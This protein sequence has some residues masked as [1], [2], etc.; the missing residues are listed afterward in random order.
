MGK[1]QKFI[2]RDISWLSFNERVLQEAAD[3]N[4][5]LI[6]R[7]KFL[8]IFSNNLDEFFRVRFATIKRMVQFE[9]DVTLTGGLKPKQVLRMIQDVVLKQRFK[10]EEV[11]QDIL[12]KLAEQN[13]FIVN[14][15]ELTEKQGQF[16]KE[17]FL[18]KVRPVLIPIMIDRIEEFPMLRDR[19]IPCRETAEIGQAR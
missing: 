13:I 1:K 9:P 16:V 12:K 17:Y 7:L 2:N 14:E 18:E 6:E 8:G 10:F 15:Q 4:T 11:Y 5:P 19:D 3:E